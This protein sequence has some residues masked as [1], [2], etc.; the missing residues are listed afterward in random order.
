MGISA[1]Q[2]LE[3]AT[4]FVKVVDWDH[5]GLTPEQVNDIIVQL[6]KDG[7]PATE[8]VKNGGRVNLVVLPGNFPTWKTVRIPVRTKEEWLR[9]LA[10]RNIEVSTYAKDVMGKPEFR[11]LTEEVEL[12][13]VKLEVRNLGFSDEKNLPT[14]SEITE[15][16]STFGLEKCPPESGPAL[17]LEASKDDWF[18]V[19]MASITG[20]GGD[21]DVFYAVRGDG[22]PRLDTDYVSPQRRFDLGYVVVFVR[23]KQ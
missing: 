12:G 3:F 21:P 14:W 8:F 15:R 4:T 13:F 5:L 20:S 1:G 19:A 6:Q 11:T 10:S 2:Q 18:W 7:R 22:R 23:R 9:K 16:A 17:R